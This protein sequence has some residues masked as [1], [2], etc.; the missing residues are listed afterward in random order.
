MGQ[1]RNVTFLLPLLFLLSEPGV[2]WA[3]SWPSAGSQARGTTRSGVRMGKQCGGE[4]RP[5][6]GVWE[7]ARDQTSWSTNSGLRVRQV[8]RACWTPGEALVKLIILCTRQR[9][10]SGVRRLERQ[11]EQSPSLNLALSFDTLLTFLLWP[12]PGESRVLWTPGF[13]R[14][15]QLNLWDVRSSTFSPKRP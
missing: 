5:R 11:E 6:G 4:R 10:P 12:Q 9:R 3:G 14:L 2:G 8:F 15:G 13:L 1:V 7:A